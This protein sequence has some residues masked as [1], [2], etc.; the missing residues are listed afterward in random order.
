MIMEGTLVRLLPGCGLVPASNRAYRRT[1][2]ARR[3][4][5]ANFDMTSVTEPPKILARG[6]WIFP[7]R[8]LA[9][10]KLLLPYSGMWAHH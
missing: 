4:C 10:A 1:L 3:R 5:F 8:M 9:G 6:Q 7:G 2:R